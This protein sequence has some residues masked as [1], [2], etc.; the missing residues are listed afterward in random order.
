MAHAVSVPSSIAFLRTSCIEHLNF[1]HLQ[2]TFIHV[3]YICIHRVKIVKSSFSF[4]SSLQSLSF[5]RQLI[6]IY[7]VGA[8]STVP[9]MFNGGNEEL[10]HQVPHC[11]FRPG[12]TFTT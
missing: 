5:Q 7:V 3:H 12:G 11:C 2:C 8:L 9:T 1:H 6:R 10:I 4:I